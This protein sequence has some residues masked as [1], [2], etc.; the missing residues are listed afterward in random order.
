MHRLA[1]TSESICLP[2]SAEPF[3][4]YL[5]G[6]DARASRK[7]VIFRQGSRHLHH[8]ALNFPGSQAAAFL[9]VHPDGLVLKIGQ[10]F[11]GHGTLQKSPGAFGT[12]MAQYHN[13]GTLFGTVG[14]NI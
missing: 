12:S 5:C 6:R 10:Y 4:G 14:Q 11:L 7:K 3:A 1:P 8:G 13:A 9:L 2:G